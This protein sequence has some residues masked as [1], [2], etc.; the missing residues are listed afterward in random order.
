MLRYAIFDLDDT[1]YSAEAG[2]M[3]HITRLIT[4]YM[5]ERVG[6][7]PEQ[8]KELRPRFWQQYGTTLSGLMQEFDV[9][10]GDYL[11]YV[12]NFPVEECLSNDPRLAQALQLLPLEKVI[13][14]N[15]SAA[16]ARRVTSFLG[17]EDQFRH[18]F[19]IAF[20]DY[21][22][23]P[24]PESFRKVL[25]ALE[26]EGKQCMLIDD[27]P[28]NLRAAAALGMVTVH[29]GPEQSNHDSDFALRSA[30]QIHDVV[31]ELV[32]RGLL[33]PDPVAGKVS[34]RI[35]LQQESAVESERLTP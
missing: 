8:T 4:R 32:A 13:F 2:V 15:A 11:P 21:V 12:H 25:R 14:T 9:D 30:S 3:R 19:D 31:P 29:V 22:S 17:I 35:G 7:T 28:A 6:L 10:P 23:K 18:I 16:H 5:V 24:D 1:L 20:V 27:N 26:V 33:L 34:Q